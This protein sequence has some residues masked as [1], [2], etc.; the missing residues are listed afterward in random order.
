LPDPGQ[1]GT[2][3]CPGLAFLVG[4]PGQINVF[5]VVWPN[6]DKDGQW[7]LPYRRIQE[8]IIVE[9]GS[10]VAAPPDPGQTSTK[11]GSGYFPTEGFRKASYNKD[12]R[13]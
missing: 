4:K 2:P 13:W 12:I 7:I 5:V 8:S 3:F 1:K 9:W 11:M 10:E 6:I